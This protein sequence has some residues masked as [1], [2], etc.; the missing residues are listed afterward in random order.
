MTID[1]IASLYPARSDRDGRLSL[2]SRQYRRCLTKQQKIR[3]ER[4]AVMSG[5]T[6]TSITNDFYAV[7]S[8]VTS[9]HTR[10][11]SLV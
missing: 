3:T 10:L 11:I 5:F 1:S 9:A 6:Y 2:S 4:K 8:H 7:D